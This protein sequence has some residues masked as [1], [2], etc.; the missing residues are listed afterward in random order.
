M[1]LNELTLLELSTLSIQNIIMSLSPRTY[2]CDGHMIKL[3]LY[4]N[5]QILL[6]E[7]MTDIE[8]SGNIRDY[9]M[10][11]VEKLYQK[12]TQYMSKKERRH[13]ALHWLESL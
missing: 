1:N 3:L 11:I 13:L 4:Y 5:I 2:I 10:D 12:A 6:E 8:N 7:I 9:V